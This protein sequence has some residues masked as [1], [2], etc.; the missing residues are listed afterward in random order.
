MGSAGGAAAHEVQEAPRGAVRVGVAS[1]VCIPHN[2]EPKSSEMFLA[3]WPTALSEGRSP[4]GPEGGWQWPQ[5]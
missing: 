3:S 5:A 4:Q 2:L 1:S